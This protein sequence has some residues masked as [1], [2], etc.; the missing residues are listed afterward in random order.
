MQLEMVMVKTETIMTSAAVAKMLGVT[1]G[2]IN[3]WLKLG[4][5]PN[6]FRLSPT[7]K[8][9]WRIPK[10]DVDKFVAD[11]RATRGYFYVPPQENDRSDQ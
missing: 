9:P 1:Q 11:R 8:S 2:A 4:Y 5:F 7:P 10:S 6:A 3:Q